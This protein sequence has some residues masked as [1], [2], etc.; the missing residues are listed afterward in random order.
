MSTENKNKS[1]APTKQELLEKLEEQ[2]RLI[3]ELLSRTNS[4]AVSDVANQRDRELKAD[5]LITVVSLYNGKL[6]LS[7][8]GNGKGTVFKFTKF[9]EKKR[10][11]YSD[12]IAVIENQ[13]SF[14]EAGRFYIED[15]DVV[16]RHGLNDLYK[17]ILTK[18]KMEEVFQCNPESSL[19]LYKIA[20][21]S[22]RDVI[23]RILINK[24]VNEED[25]DLNIVSSISL[26][27]KKKLIE[28]ADE[29][30]YSKELK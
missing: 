16:R 4:G 14:L 27:G 23:N 25:I 9:G 7:T 5:D 30:K 6:N 18:E 1:K 21:E 19:E 28:I 11:L 13:R 26:L 17:N 3:A 15:S 22:Q 20:N 2:E 8:L 12:L 24:L 29:I 10:I